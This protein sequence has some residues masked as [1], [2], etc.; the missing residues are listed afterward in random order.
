MCC[1]VVVR[2]SLSGN[3]ARALW[4]S[5]H[6]LEKKNDGSF[7]LLLLLFYFLCFYLFIFLCFPCR[8]ACMFD[9]DSDLRGN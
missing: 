2:G 9:V 4:V 8:H 7:L 1:A 3:G 6:S 5:S